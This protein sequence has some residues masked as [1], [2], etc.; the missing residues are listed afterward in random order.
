MLD[1]IKAVTDSLKLVALLLVTFSV[2]F[3]HEGRSGAPSAEPVMLMTGL[4]ATLYRPDSILPVPGEAFKKRKSVHRRS[5][6]LPE[7]CSVE[8]P[9]SFFLDKHHSVQCQPASRCYVWDTEDGWQALLLAGEAQIKISS[10]TDD[11]HLF[12]VSGPDPERG[13]DSIIEASP[14]KQ[15]LPIRYQ[16]S[17][18]EWLPVASQAVLPGVVIDDGLDRTGLKIGLLVEHSR[19]VQA[20]M[21]QLRSQ[22][23]NPDGFIYNLK[24][25]RLPRRLMSDVAE[26]LQKTDVFHQDLPEQLQ[27]RDLIDEE[28]SGE[29]DEEKVTGNLP[30]VF[31]WKYTKRGDPVPEFLLYDGKSW[32]PL[33]LLGEGRD[34]LERDESNGWALFHESMDGYLYDLL[35]PDDVAIPPPIRRSWVRGMIPEAP[36]RNN[37]KKNNTEDNSKGVAPPAP[38]QEPVSSPVPV[39][40]AGKVTTDSNVTP[41]SKSALLGNSATFQHHT[42]IMHKGEVVAMVKAHLEG[43]S[44]AAIRKKVLDSRSEG[45]AS[46][47][48][49][50]CDELF[51][52]ESVSIFQSTCG[53][54]V[55]GTCAKALD[56]TKNAEE[57]RSVIITL[58]PDPEKK[59]SKCPLCENP[60]SKEE[61]PKSCFK[62]LFQD[63][64]AIREF[65]VEAMSSDRFCVCGIQAQDSDLSK[66]I[67]YDCPS[68]RVRCPFCCGSVVLKA[69]DVHL[70]RC[71]AYQDSSVHCQKCSQMVVVNA[72]GE[73]KRKCDACKKGVSCLES[74]DHD[75]AC[76][77]PCIYR[78]VGCPFTGIRADLDRHYKESRNYHDKLIVHLSV[79]TENK[80]TCLSRRM[81]GTHSQQA[82]GGGTP[83]NYECRIQTAISNADNKIATISNIQ[84]D[85]QHA[86]Q[87]LQNYYSDLALSIQTLQ[88][89]SYNGVYIWK[90]PEL[91]RR[92]REAVLGKTVSL[93]S[94]PFFTS[95]HGYKLCLRV[96]LNGDGSGRG[97]HLSLFITLM[98]GE[99]DQLLPWPFKQQVSLS[100]LAQDGISRDITQSFKP[101]QESSS[102]LM[103][104]SE[105]NVAS[106]CPEFCSLAVLEN[107]SYI[108][109][110]TLYLKG[111]INLRGIEHI[112]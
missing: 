94:A 10:D 74:D 81:D 96:Y 77:R 59:P 105:M 75:Q 100:L 63:R 60:L 61:H 35:Y 47:S 45:A 53:S 22:E 83:P 34:T 112:P 23:I 62:T 86:F 7:G 24:A 65:K 44:P 56:K 85:M 50:L 12:P 25:D 87:N 39:N 98:K 72:F 46:L 11:Y 15:A 84:I 8:E 52:G 29:P 26:W 4:L 21:Q 36:K 30:Y 17:A 82:G 109:A 71:K 28:V 48:C 9:C 106:G 14:Q 54:R 110:D 2:M 55:C 93:Y 80:L 92:R 13:L 32:K 66:H 42:K 104:K 16:D 5:F 31:R 95:R 78:E 67:L 43:I 27:F 88:A 20:M 69:Y 19:Q 40:Q 99:F 64:A 18:G 6:Q 103:P 101:N 90:V 57:W 89:T 33:D 102:F 3:C 79:S 38:E 108:H 58:N 97:T 111:Q 1:S 107:P 41:P 51:G 49:A 91:T 70:K 68:Y 76:E 37:R 73:H